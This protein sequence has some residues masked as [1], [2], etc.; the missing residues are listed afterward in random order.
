MPRSFANWNQFRRPGPN[1]FA[2]QPPATSNSAGDAAAP[3]AAANSGPQVDELEILISGLFDDGGESPLLQS[4]MDGSESPRASPND[5]HSADDPACSFLL[6]RGF[7]N[8]PSNDGSST[9][10]AAMSSSSS[11]AAAVPA[12]GGCT[13]S[14]ALAVHQS[15]QGGGSGQPTPLALP[16]LDSAHIVAPTGGR[17][18]FVDVVGRTGYRRGQ[19]IK[20]S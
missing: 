2:V 10:G 7:I 6:P 19:L 11:G 3:A 14:Q 13:A 4:Q 20:Q 5:E 9:A 1:L 17:V 16:S 18:L 8:E 15:F 12:V